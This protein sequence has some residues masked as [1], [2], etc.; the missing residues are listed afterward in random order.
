[1]CEPEYIVGIHAFHM[2]L[3]TDVENCRDGFVVDDATTL[4]TDGFRLVIILSLRTGR[5]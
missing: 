3:K 2:Y 1:M 4:K 5:P